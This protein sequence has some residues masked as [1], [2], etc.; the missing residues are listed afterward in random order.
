MQ[1]S[2]FHACSCRTLDGAASPASTARWALTW[3]SVQSASH[4]TAMHPSKLP[5]PCHRYLTCAFSRMHYFHLQVPFKNMSMN[6]QRVNHNNVG[7]QNGLLRK[8]TERHLHL[9]GAGWQ[10]LGGCPEAAEQLVQVDDQ[11]NLVGPCV[12]HHLQQKAQQNS[13]A[14][15]TIMRFAPIAH[16]TLHNSSFPLISR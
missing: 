16:L 13:N 10:L 3:R 9:L 7:A 14:R 5:S 2:H 8:L 11:G 1:Y 4:Q 12:L 6:P 15:A